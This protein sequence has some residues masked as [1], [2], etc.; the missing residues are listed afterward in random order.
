MP[1]SNDR[2]RVAAYDFLRGREVGRFKEAMQIA[3]GSVEIV[4]SS[5]AVALT[6]TSRVE[7]DDAVPHRA[8][9]KARITNE[10]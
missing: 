5:R 10:L 9:P 1:L 3:C 7:H 2:M 4:S 8:Y 6:E